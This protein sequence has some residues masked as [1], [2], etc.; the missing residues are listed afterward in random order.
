[1]HHPF[2]HLMY[3][4]KITNQ[5]LRLAIIWGSNL[6]QALFRNAANCQVQQRSLAT[7]RLPSGSP[8]FTTS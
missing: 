7:D 5:A 8:E 4:Q 3:N 1:M 6:A 2:H